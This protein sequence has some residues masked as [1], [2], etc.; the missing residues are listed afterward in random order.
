MEQQLETNNDPK[1]NKVFKGILIGGVVGGALVMMNRSARK[2]VKSKA[3]SLKDSSTRLVTEVKNH[4]GEVKDQLI[5]QFKSASDTLKDAI[6]DAQ[7]LYQRVNEDIS[8]QFVAMKDASSQAVSSV[9][10]AKGD[11]TKISSKV[12][13]AQSELTENPIEHNPSST[14]DQDKLEYYGTDAGTAYPR[15]EPEPVTSTTTPHK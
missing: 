14:K 2:K 10:N 11:I 8:S 9:K 12:K 7:K 6:L 13:D 1:N 5:N 3:V 15:K 4:P